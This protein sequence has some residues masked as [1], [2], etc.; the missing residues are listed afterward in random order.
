MIIQ[1]P[2][3]STKFSVDSAKI[4]TLSNP[5]FHCSR[6]D[7]F[8][9]LHGKTKH[10]TVPQPHTE[11]P[12]PVR[13]PVETA[14][15]GPKQLDLLSASKSAPEPEAPIS[16]ALTAPALR[17][18]P[19]DD[20]D[21]PLI[22]ADWPEAT[23]AKL[24]EADLSEVIRKTPGAEEA[25]RPN[26]RARLHEP[27][28]TTESSLRIQESGRFLPAKE[29]SSSLLGAE[30]VPEIRDEIG[31]Q[32][33][34]QELPKTPAVERPTAS[35][36]LFPHRKASRNAF[37]QSAAA[38]D[39]DLE[40]SIFA[41]EQKT[42]RPVSA[43]LFGWL[44][45]LR[46]AASPKYL[47]SLAL[48][49]AG[50]ALLTSAFWFWGSHFGSTPSAI[51]AAVRLSPQDFPRLAPPGLEV[52]GLKA[53]TV[54]LADGNKVLEIKGTIINSTPK[55]YNDLEIEARLFDDQNQLVDKIVAPSSNGL[56]NVSTLQTL[57]PEV[58]S[59]FQQKSG[60]SHHLKPNE[61]FPF[62]VVFTSN[63]DTASWFSARVLSVKPQAS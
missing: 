47:S 46:T 56:L 42:S 51:T 36:V 26:F 44:T 32:P 37:A 4:Q 57:K 53:Q 19:S 22:T 25:V 17:A 50:P 2:S 34:T 39:A 28:V 38:A 10:R 45:K 6:C 12:E 11:V 3:C 52:V 15:K 33:L 20:D 14:G 1:C 21:L 55:T 13:D 23:A 8:F 61:Q 59:D 5:K 9:D 29:E 41:L 48:A 63:Q 54:T 30:E 40:T 35:V 58:I 62:R 7:H 24:H 60:L 43:T 27:A 18:A 16:R 31:E 49:L